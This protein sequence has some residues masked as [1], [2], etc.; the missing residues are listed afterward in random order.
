MTTETVLDAPQGTQ[1][2]DAIDPQAQ[3]PAADAPGADEQQPQGEQ[4]GEQKPEL[5]P[6]QRA[7][8]KMERRIHT[9]TAGRGAAQREAEM[10]RERLAALETQRPATTQQQEDDEQP[11]QRPVIDPREIDRIATQRADEIARQR[12]IA[13]RSADVMRAGSKLEGF[14]DAVNTVADEVPF[15]DRAGRPTA[16]IEAVLD[17]EAPAAILHYL[18]QNPEEAAAFADLGPAQI[19]RRIARLEDKLKVSAKTQTSNAPRPLK[20]VQPNGAGEKD[21][22]KMTD[23]EFAAWRKAQIAKRNS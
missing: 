21:P 4:Q 20:P 2:T 10:L 13:R 5:T 7:M 6:E 1:Q 8:R 11:Q 3:R 19:G 14:D 17:S 23:T 9:L 22:S 16:F 18:G 15:T 12:D